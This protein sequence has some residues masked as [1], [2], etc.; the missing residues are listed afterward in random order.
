MLLMRPVGMTSRHYAEHGLVSCPVR[1]MD[2]KVESCLRC[3]ALRAMTDDR[4]CVI[5]DG[6]APDRSGERGPAAERPA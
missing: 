3:R 6:Q 1:G 4:A 5:C 2:V